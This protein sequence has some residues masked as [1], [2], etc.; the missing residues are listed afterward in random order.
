MNGDNAHWSIGEV[1]MLLQEDFPEVTI[2]KIRFLESQGLINP[3][4]TPSGYRRF[5]EHDFDRLRW[6]L[7]QQRDKY[8]PLKVI[9]DR[10][11][12]GEPLDDPVAADQPD[13]LSA[14]LSAPLV[15]LT[16]TAAATAGQL[17]ADASHAGPQEAAAHGSKHP[18]DVAMLWEELASDVAAALIDQ[19]PESARTI[20]ADALLDAENQSSEPSPD[21]QGPHQAPDRQE[22]VVNQSEVHADPLTREELAERTGCGVPF[23]HELE[24]FQMIQGSKV[25]GAV[26]FDPRAIEVV[27]LA[28]R[29]AAHGLDPRHL[30]AFRL[31]AE[32]EVGL[33]AQIIE[34][35]LHRRDPSARREVFEQLDT[36]A[37]DA[38]AL[39]LLMVQSLLAEQFPD[40]LF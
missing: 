39:H 4:R 35:G 16:D 18:R 19:P 29:F 10:L 14:F 32:R 8:L 6:I 9:R 13:I 38:E 21:Q 15:D 1:L 40:R 3:E 28:A 31:A 24:R 20:A 12:S 26:L 33:I 22:N 34:P 25:G 5:Y 2:S 11:E 7:T 36:L 17:E 30:R 27:R 23:L 37:A